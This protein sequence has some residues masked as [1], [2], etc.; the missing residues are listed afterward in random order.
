MISTLRARGL[1]GAKNQMQSRSAMGAAGT[2]LLTATFAGLSFVISIVL[3]RLLGAEGY[4]A[5]AYAISWVTFLIT[6]ALFGLDTL[7]VRQI[8][9]YVTHEKWPLCARHFNVGAAHRFFGGKRSLH[10][11]SLAARGFFCKA[12]RRKIARRF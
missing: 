12:R 5:Y 10:L 11:L 6:P 4:G 9:V 7:I 1:Q 3:A 8:A 2:F